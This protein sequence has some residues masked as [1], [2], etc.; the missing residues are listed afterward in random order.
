MSSL[1]TILLYGHDHVLLMTRTLL[2]ERAGFRVKSTLSQQEAARLS[3]I[4]DLDLLVLCHTLK[5]EEQEQTMRALR[6]ARPHLRGLALTQ[7]EGR[8]APAED[9]TEFV[10]RLEGPGVLLARIERMMR[11]PE[12]RMT[13][14]LGKAHGYSFAARAE[15]PEIVMNY[16]WSGKSEE[17]C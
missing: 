5:R 1:G 15:N 7:G 12:R 6:D 8:A 3:E 10:N 16:T 9:V 2:F 11:E 14:K 4:E 13:L 17:V